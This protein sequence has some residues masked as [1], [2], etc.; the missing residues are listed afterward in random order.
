MSVFLLIFGVFGLAALYLLWFYLAEG[1]PIE[2]VDLAYDVDAN[3]IE[4]TVKNKDH[5]SYHLLSSLRLNANQPPE[6][7]KDIADESDDDVTMLTGSTE[8]NTY[9]GRYT[10]IDE[11]LEANPI[12]P[13]ETK[14]FT[15]VVGDDVDLE[16]RHPISVSIFYGGGDERLEGTLHKKIKLNY[17]QGSSGKQKASPPVC[18]ATSAQEPEKITMKE[19]D[20]LIELLD[21]IEA[22][23]EEND[24]HPYL[25]CVSAE[26][27]FK[28]KTGHADIIDDIFFLED[29]ANAVS[30][31]PDEAIAFHLER[32]NDFARWVND[33]IGDAELAGR[34]EG[35]EYSSAD[36]TRQKIVEAMEDRIIELEGGLDT[37]FTDDSPRP[38]QQS[39]A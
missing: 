29:L 24:Q 21:E 25:S 11:D 2:I 9:Q 7:R 18:E 20:S 26:H 19:Y 3:N 8:N 4:L 1:K 35:I 12:D 14:T 16:N 31:V 15:Y 13:E 37:I 36:E 28:L 17:K 22:D 10:L 39:S 23:I 38:P 34:L 33:V 6:E 30:D 5:R 27:S 32:G